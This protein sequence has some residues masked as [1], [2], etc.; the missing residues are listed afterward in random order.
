M[1]QLAAR[2][3]R[4]ALS[5]H[6]T[7]EGR[8]AVEMRRLRKVP[9][10]PRAAKPPNGPRIA[11]RDRPLTPEQIARIGRLGGLLD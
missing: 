3:L 10:A 7:I 5:H 4:L 6:R 2:I 11:P 9:R 1:N 8:R